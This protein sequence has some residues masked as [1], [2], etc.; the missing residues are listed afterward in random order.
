MAAEREALAAMLA[1]RA[2]AARREEASV[3][4]EAAHMTQEATTTTV[5]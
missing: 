1:V 3:A 4:E 2:N 5:A